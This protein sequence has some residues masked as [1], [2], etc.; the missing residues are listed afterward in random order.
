MTVSFLVDSADEAAFRKEVRDWLDESLAP[1]LRGWSVRPPFALARPWHRKIYDR[2]WIAPHWPKKY[3]GMEATL[4][5]QLIL[6]EEF[7][8]AG[9]PELSHQAL[10]HI[11]PIL[12]HHGTE[13]QKAQHLPPMLSG[14]AVWCQGYSEPNAGSDLASLTTRAEAGDKE[15]TV[16][17]QKIWTT[18]AH[19]AQWMYALV[20]TDPDVPKKQMGISL[21]L[22]D[23]KTP[24]ITIRPICTLADDEEF[25]EVFFDDVKVP[26]ENLVGGLHEGW[27]V[28]KAVLTNE[29]VGAGRSLPSTGWLG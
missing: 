23:L 25:A 18:W 11:G 13:K 17:G 29:R 28:A 26:R 5:Q 6:L 19:N 1:E 2:G 16:N 21:I 12:M 4:N 3:G 15:F 8:A 27:T 10:N 20:R 9:A 14:D 22:L 7:A 24:G